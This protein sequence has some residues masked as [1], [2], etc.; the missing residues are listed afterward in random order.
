MAT[1]R[2]KALAAFPELRRWLNTH[3]DT[4]YTYYTLFF[5]LLP[6]SRD[7]HASGDA[8]TLR[9]IYE[10]AEWCLSQRNRADDLYN[11][12]LVAFYEHLFDEQEDWAKVL[13][14]LTRAVFD[15]C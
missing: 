13:P 9:A 4:H 1:W 8:T 7:A 2:R 5:D 6:M 10:F 12:A 11:A 15:E 3:D 14:W